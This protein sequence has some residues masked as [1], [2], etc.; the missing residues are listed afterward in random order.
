M[1]ASPR[2][3]LQLPIHPKA[4][5]AGHEVQNLKKHGTTIAYYHF[6][7]LYAFWFLPGDPAKVI[8]FDSSFKSFH[9]IF[10]STFRFDLYFRWSYFLQTWRYLCAGPKNFE[11]WMNYHVWKPKIIHQKH[12][13][14]LNTRTR[15]FFNMR[16]FIVLGW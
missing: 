6:K 1:S 12:A 15:S 2:Y 16:Y 11:I 4:G 9:C 13:E 5:A 3:I 14:N 8:L 10:N 7:K